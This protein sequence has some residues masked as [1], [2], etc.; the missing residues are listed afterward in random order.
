VLLEHHRDSLQLIDP[1]N[2]VFLHLSAIPHSAG[3]LPFRRP[4][5]LTVDSPHRR[6]PP[7]VQSTNSIPVVRWC[8]LA[9]P[10]SPPCTETAEP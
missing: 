6:S 7:P 5:G 3:E 8:S 10:N 2:F 1:P 4:F 9:H